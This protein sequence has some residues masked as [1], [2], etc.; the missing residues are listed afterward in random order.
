MSA[1]SRKILEEALALPPM[2]RASLVDELL[3]SF[4]FPAR[5]EVDALW[6]AEAEDRID[7]CD[8][9]EMRAI[10]ADKVFER[11]DQEQVR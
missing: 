7:A 1:Q 6:A 10:P 8:R 4:D 11:I 2:E 5:Q 9:G 3:S